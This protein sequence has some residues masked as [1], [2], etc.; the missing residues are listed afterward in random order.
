MIVWFYLHRF[1]RCC[2]PN[3][4]SSAKFRENLNLFQDHPRSITLAPIE[5][6]YATFYWSLSCTVPEMIRCNYRINLNGNC[7]FFLPLCLLAPQLPMFPFEFHGEVNREE[8]TVIDLGLLCG[9][10]CMILTSTLFDWCTRVT[11][12]RADRRTADGIS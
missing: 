12:R 9:E 6:A 8:T 10:S 7:V 5:S 3:M 1:S 2:L 11:D 4:R